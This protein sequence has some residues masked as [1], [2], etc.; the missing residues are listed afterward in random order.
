MA[1]TIS[2][3]TCNDLIGKWHYH[4]RVDDPGYD[5]A[6]EETVVHGERDCETVEGQWDRGP[7]Q[8]LDMAKKY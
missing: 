8:Y 3:R 6:F 2:T 1:A 7:S 5:D 4:S